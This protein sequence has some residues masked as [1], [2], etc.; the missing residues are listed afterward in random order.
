MKA[1]GAEPNPER[2]KMHREEARW[3]AQLPRTAPVPQLLGIYDDGDWATVILEDVAGR[4]PH[5]PW[6]MGELR[7]VMTAI[8]QLQAQLT[9]CPVPN[10]PTFVERH[11]E[12]FDGWRELAKAPD[13]SLDPRA[14]RRLG[15][16]AERETGWPEAVTGDTLLHAYLRADNL[17]VTDASSVVFLD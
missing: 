14:R 11:R 2:P 1:V 15:R 17:L 3:L 4:H 13:R 12:T 7:R 8:E 16:L 9:P 6:R 5:L 10:L